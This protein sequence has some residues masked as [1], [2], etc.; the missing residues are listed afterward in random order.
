M[1][2]RSGRLWGCERR[3]DQET[4]QDSSFKM[5]MQ[6]KKAKESLD[7]ADNLSPVQRNRIKEGL[8]DIKAGR[9]VPR[10]KVWAKYGRKV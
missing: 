10:N 5:L 1:G 8:E 9:T 4:V 2:L 7:R 6:F 3:T